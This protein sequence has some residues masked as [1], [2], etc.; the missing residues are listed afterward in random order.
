MAE[1]ICCL[2]DSD[3]FFRQPVQIIHPFVNRGIHFFNP[4]LECVTAILFF[5]QR[6]SVP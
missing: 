4:P 1:G 3:F 5:V 2:N 6:S